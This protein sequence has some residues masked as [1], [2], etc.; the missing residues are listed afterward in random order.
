VN[1]NLLFLT[2][3]NLVNYGGVQHQINLMNDYINKNTKIKSKIAAPNSKD[4]DLGDAINI[5]F[6]NSIASISLFPDRVSL[7]KAIEWSDIIHIHEPFIPL[8]FWKLPKDKKYI[9]THH[10]NLN[11]LY[12]FFMSIIYKIIK[13]KGV[14]VYVS[15]SALSNAKTLNDHPILI[16]NMIEINKNIEYNINKKLLFVGRNEKRKNF[17]FFNLLSKENSLQDYEFEA[18]TNEKI[19]NFNGVIHL[20]PNED[21]KIKILQNS[22][23]YLALNTKHE[24]FGITLIE[25]INSGNVVICSDLVAFKNV[26]DESGIYYKRNSYESLLNLLTNTVN[27]DLRF[28]WKKQYETIQKYDI[29]INMENYIL[30]YLNK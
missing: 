20:K 30:L 21:E 7:L 15:E 28:L 2:P 14:S 22:S 26:L 13:I 5:P 17:N 4:Y 3:Y 9:F 27:S 10:A 16:P 1:T 11:R 29:D 18:I 12:T 8:M 25:A 6:N 24:S 19:G 23:I